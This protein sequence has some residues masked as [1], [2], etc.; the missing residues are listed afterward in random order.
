M[1]IFYS[2]LRVVVHSLRPESQR[3]DYFFLMKIWWLSGGISDNTWII[4]FTSDIN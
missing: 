4:T 3:P 1:D 2:D